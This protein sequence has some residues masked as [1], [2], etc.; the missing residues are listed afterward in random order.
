MM[1]GR[2]DVGGVRRP[3]LD[4]VAVDGLSSAVHRPGHLQDVVWHVAGGSEAVPNLPPLLPVIQN[5][6]DNAQ[7]I[8]WRVSAPPLK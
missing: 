2:R 8:T 5:L 1:E 7:G 4:G 6:R 3:Y